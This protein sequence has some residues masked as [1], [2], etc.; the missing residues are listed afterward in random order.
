MKIGFRGVD[1]PAKF[2][3]ALITIGF[4]VLQILKSVDELYLDTPLENQK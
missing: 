1:F 2:M 3:V 4:R